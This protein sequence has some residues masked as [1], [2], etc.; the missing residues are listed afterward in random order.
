MTSIDIR[1][2]AQQALEA[3]NLDHNDYKA[4][5][6]WNPSIALGQQYTFGATEAKE[7]RYEID[8]TGW[9]QDP[10]LPDSPPSDLRGA[11]LSTFQRLTTPEAAREMPKGSVR[12]TKAAADILNNYA[13][14]LGAE[15]HFEA[16]QQRPNHPVG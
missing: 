8:R 4:F 14:D 10:M 11:V 12:L 16:H 2:F 6:G 7:L 3:S 9:F 5:S 1:A 15:V 13:K